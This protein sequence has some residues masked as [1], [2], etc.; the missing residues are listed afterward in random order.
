ML[1]DK[2]CKNAIC[3][4][5]KK[6]ARFTDSLGLYLEVSPSG[7]K[8][9]FWKT[10]FDGKEGRMALGSYPTQSL[11]DARKAR[12]IAKL[13]KADGVDPVQERKLEKLKGSRSGGDTFQAIALEWHGRQVDQWSDTHAGRTKRQL[14]RD[15]FPWIGDRQMTSIEPME[16]LATLQKIEERGAMETA[17]R[18]LMLCRQIWRYWLPTAGNTQR[19][20]TVGLKNRL[21]PYRGTNF[22]AIVEPKRFGELLRAMHVYKGSHTVRTALLLAPLL[23]QR[24]GNLRAMEWAEVDLDAALWT[25]PSMKM[26]RTKT[27]KEQGEP[28]AVPL[29]TQAVELLRNLQALTG[30]GTYVFPGQRDHERPMSDNSVRSALYSLGFG[31]EQSW[32]GFRASARTMLVDQLD[33]DPLAIEANLAH[34]VKDSNGRSYNRTQYLKKRYNQVQMWADYL[35]RLRLG[36]EVVPLVRQA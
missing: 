7:S 6:R 27:E 19:D 33:L 5:D 1:T 16:L 8:R 11:A 21:T 18:A 26:K 36:A 24:P 20:I 17:D 12:D 30:R 10:Y 31:T 25:I 15:L 29:P 2:Q 22:P 34:A 3:P 13:K 28:H 32:H 14:E 23:Y 9:W 35:D 4:P